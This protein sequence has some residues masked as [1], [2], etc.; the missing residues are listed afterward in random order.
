MI[1]PSIKALILN[2]KRVFLRS[3]LNISV[4]KRHILSDF[5]L[6]STLPTIDYILKAGGKIVLGTHIG[7]PEAQSKTHF[8]D[9]ELS[10]QI[11][12]PWFENRGY[13]IEYQPDLLQAKNQS[14]INASSI[15]LLENLRFFNGEKEYNLNFAELLAATADIYVNDA[16]GLIHRSDTSVTLLAKQFDKNHRGFGFLIEQELENLEKIRNNTSQN[17]VLVLG[18]IKLK[19]KLP[20]LKKLIQNNDQIKPKSIIIGGP[21]GLAFLESKVPESFKFDTETLD[22]ANQIKQMATL[23]KI[24][25]LLPVDQIIFNDN[26]I[27][28]VKINEITL[29]SQCVDIGPETITLFS[30]EIQTADVIFCNGTMGIYTEEYAQNGTQKILQAIADSKA[31]KVVGGGDATAATCM[32]G[33]EEKMSFLSSGGGATL[34][35]LGCKNPEQEM[36]GLNAMIYE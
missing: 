17:F 34:K 30:Q 15:L 16:F 29:D 22:M 8:Y 10:T 31:F 3:D 35:Y 24:N 7:R 1:L 33:L 21:L 32:F 11:L 26:K 23:N 4:Y 6:K 18:G 19:D 36:P 25:L 13:D 14:N 9:D 5:K 2:K 20:L 28:T 12:I 27:E